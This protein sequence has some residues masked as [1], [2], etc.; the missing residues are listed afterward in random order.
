MM[1][2]VY[3]WLGIL[4]VIAMVMACSDMNDLHQPFLDRGEITYAAKV[5][6]VA[7]HIGRNRI[8]FELIVK[9]QRIKTVR[10][11][12]NDYKDA[13]ADVILFRDSSDVDIS[14]KGIFKKIVDNLAERSYVFK[15][16]SFDEFGNISLPTEISAYV[17]GS[18]YQNVLVARS[19]RS[20]VVDKDGNLRI[21]WGIADGAYGSEVRYTDLSGQVQT[22]TFRIAESVS[23][24]GGVKGNTSYEFRT[25]YRPDTTGID[26]FYTDYVKV[27][28][29]FSFYKKDWK[30]IDFSSQHGGG[31]NAV[32]NLIDGTAATR[33]HTCAGCSPAASYPHHATIDMGGVRTITRFDLSI[34]T[35]E[36][37]GGD[38]RAPNKF[39]LLTSTDNVSWTD[40]GQF[41]L[42]R[43]HVGEQSYAMPEDTQARYFKF[44]GISGPDNNMVMGEI[45]AYGF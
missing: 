20:T 4:G 15:L 32:A 8:Q 36:N 6:S 21:T 11:Y 26:N 38:Q 13:N 24:V 42:N 30:I 18:K 19:M 2:Y 14:G 23:L 12:W 3:D 40:H 22:Q 1:K 29:P 16:V 25:V 33:W 31:D 35:F 27:D 34:T 37:P 44:V 28:P 17:Y 39:Q 41:D 7:T 43:F 9:S 45:T 5:D 10:I